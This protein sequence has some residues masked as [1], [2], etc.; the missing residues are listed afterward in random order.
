MKLELLASA[1]FVW[2]WQV[3]VLSDVLC[4]RTVYTSTFSYIPSASAI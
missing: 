3:E 1:I 4:Y 2:Y